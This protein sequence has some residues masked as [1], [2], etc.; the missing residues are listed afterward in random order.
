[1]RGGGIFSS[2]WSCLV[3]VSIKALWSLMKGGLNLFVFTLTCF[4]RQFC[5]FLFFFLSVKYSTVPDETFLFAADRVESPIST[6]IQLSCTISHTDMKST[7]FGSHASWRKPLKTLV[8]IKEAV[9]LETC[10]L[11]SLLQPFSSLP[12]SAGVKTVLQFAGDPLASSTG[13]REPEE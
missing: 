12:L 8:L 11:F 7:W 3:L 1:M 2:V 4:N 5:L 10:V 13:G 9:S 6:F